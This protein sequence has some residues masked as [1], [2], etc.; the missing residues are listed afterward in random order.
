MEEVAAKTKKKK[1]NGQGLTSFILGAAG[2]IIPVSMIIFIYDS[3]WHLNRDDHT[4]IYVGIALGYILFAAG[5]V[6]G[7]LGV[8]KKPKGLAVTG[9]VLSSLAL[10]AAYIAQTA[11]EM[12]DTGQFYQMLF[13]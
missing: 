3:M 9:I 6:F 8:R 5:L 10:P 4:I 7:I 2:F 1:L 12:V 13:H 11:I